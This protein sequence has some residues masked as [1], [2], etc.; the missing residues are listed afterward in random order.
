MNGGV[1][2]FLGL[3][4]AAVINAAALS[5]VARPVASFISGLEY[6]RKKPTYTASTVI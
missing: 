2:V 6:R 1:M 4:G 5:I 3:V